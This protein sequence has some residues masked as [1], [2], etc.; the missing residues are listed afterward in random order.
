[1]S[2][3]VDT[4]HKI[5]NAF[6]RLQR[7]RGLV[8]LR[9][10]VN[11]DVFDVFSS[12]LGDLL[13]MISN[14]H[15]ICAQRSSPC[16]HRLAAMQLALHYEAAKTTM[17]VIDTPKPSLLENL[18]N[19]LQKFEKDKLTDEMCFIYFRALNYLWF[20]YASRFSDAFATTRD[21]ST[22]VEEMYDSLQRSGK[23][24]FHDTHNLFAKTVN[25]STMTRGREEIDHLFAKN[26]QLLEVIYKG[27]GDTDSL[28]KI[29]Q[30]QM[31]ISH[32]NVPHWAWV[33]K[34]VPFVPLL[35][36]ESRL[37]EAAT[38]LFVAL[39]MIL[40]CPES[41]LKSDE[42]ASVKRILAAEW[43]NYAFAL[44]ESSADFLRANFS[45]EELEPLMKFLPQ[46]KC[47]EVKS[48]NDAVP[49]QSSQFDQI[50]DT[51]ATDSFG[52]AKLFNSF[53]LSPQETTFCIQS[54]EDVD[55]GRQMFR[56][57]I[58]TIDDF[59]RST[60]VASMPM[61]YITYQYQVLD[62]LLILS[63]FEKDPSPRYTAQRARL[64]RCD[65]MIEML[66]DQ[67]PKVIEIVNFQLLND[68]NDILLD[69][70]QCNLMLSNMAIKDANML[71]EKLKEIRAQSFSSTVA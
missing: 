24:N 20:L 7:L 65:E 22:R 46:P 23:Q 31:K 9:T 26:L 17:A 64:E 44:L 27:S 5:H 52:A 8:T 21:Y 19:C 63:V 41:D 68:L 35:I 47:D 25:M 39:K 28:A 53:K 16:R 6:K 66:N 11:S 33:Q 13:S 29:L 36:D 71:K 50:G 10:K 61:D 60:D 49:A 59:I 56:Y 12:Y 1:M 54:I 58:C 42:M 18:E 69:L 45:E 43:M 4:F 57:M 2:D 40:D 62:L 3:E 38:Y 32:T 48:D 67:C 70:Y 55:V 34:I 51:H 15:E 30:Q 14:E 37:K